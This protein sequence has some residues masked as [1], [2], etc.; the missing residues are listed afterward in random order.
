MT[1]STVAPVPSDPSVPSTIIVAGQPTGWSSACDAAMSA[2]RP[3][4]GTYKFSDL[5]VDPAIVAAAEHPTHLF[6]STDGGPFAAVPVSDGPTGDNTGTGFLAAVSDGFL[7]GRMKF[8]VGGGNQV[9]TTNV[10]HSVDGKTWTDFGSLDGSIVSSGS[11]GGHFTVLLSDNTG[12]VKLVRLKDDGSG[13]EDVVDSSSPTA[14]VLAA[15]GYQTSMGEAGFLAAFSNGGAFTSDVS[16]QHNGF[17]FH[18][19]QGPTGMQLLKV[20]DD[21]TAVVVADGPLI[22]DVTT[23]PSIKPDKRIRWSTDGSSDI[24]IVDDKGAT[25]VT[26]TGSDLFNQVNQKQ[27]AESVK[28]M[29]ILDSQDGV[30]WSATNVSDLVD[31]AKVP[32]IGASNLIVDKDRY[33][34]NL[35]VARSDGGPADTI[36]FVG[37][38][39]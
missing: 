22:Q 15:T 34:V 39:G 10:A 12:R 13:F 37:R 38:R 36:T 21:T 7:L 3:I 6:V 30:T 5:G 18:V 28:S 25:V 35:L 8:P 31:L 20:I 19:G 24:T 29:R 33:I 17:T 14:A 32:V 16:V 1:L 23:D 27:Q 26:I 9:V 11:V 4:A 2:P